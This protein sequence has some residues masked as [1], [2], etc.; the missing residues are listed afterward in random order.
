MQNISHFCLFDTGPHFQIL[1][2]ILERERG[3][4]Q[5]CDLLLGSL[6]GGEQPE[7]AKTVLFNRKLLYLAVLIFMNIYG[8][9][10]HTLKIAAEA[11]T[12]WW[13]RNVV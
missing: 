7:P 2:S 9:I 5:S 1:K 6:G 3:K 4:F 10:I 8:K 11:S 12:P 13:G